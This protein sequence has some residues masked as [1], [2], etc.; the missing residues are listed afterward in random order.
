MS[1]SEENEVLK[2]VRDLLRFNLR[3]TAKIEL[4]TLVIS[5]LLKSASD[6]TKLDITNALQPYLESDSAHL[7]EAAEEIYSLIAS[8]S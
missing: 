2:S 6:S 4:N 5:Y 7:V 3:N 8:S 1:P